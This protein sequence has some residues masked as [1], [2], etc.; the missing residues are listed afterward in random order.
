MAVKDNLKPIA[1]AVSVS[2]EAEAVLSNMFVQEIREIGSQHFYICGFDNR[3]IIVAV[4]GIGRQKA[5]QG[6]ESLI[7]EYSPSMIISLGFAGAV[8][9]QITRGRIILGEEIITDINNKPLFNSTPKLLDM[10]ENGLGKAL[11]PYSIGKIFTISKPLLGPH[12][13][14]AFEKQHQCLAVEMETAGVAEIAYREGIHFLS[15]RF[16]LDEV[17]D[18]LKFIFN[19]IDKNGRI[20]L[21]EVG[22]NILIL[23]KIIKAYLDLRNWWGISCK[24]V[25]GGLVPILR[26]II[27]NY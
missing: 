14:I 9:A 2:R 15:I 3:K 22:R 20:S 21:P 4:L 24:S 16:V 17:Q 25:E 27:K 7:Q 12:E 1:I 23:P 19:F 5:I 13:K 18:D 8:N 26:E 6:T 11:I 10:A